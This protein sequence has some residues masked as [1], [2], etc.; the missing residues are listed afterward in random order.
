MININDDL[1]IY[2]TENGGLEISIDSNKDTIW[3]TQAQMCILFDKDQSVISRHLKN[4]FK[5][6]ELDE[7]SN[8]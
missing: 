1:A 5:S 8:M 6:N 3:A 2:Q 7:K 4:V